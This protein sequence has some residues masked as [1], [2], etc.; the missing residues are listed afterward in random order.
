MTD[1]ETKAVPVSPSALIPVGGS[2]FFNMQNVSDL[3]SLE[4]QAPPFHQA[5][6]RAIIA[7]G[8]AR[9]EDYQ[10]EHVTVRQP[11]AIPTFGVGAQARTREGKRVT[12]IQASAGYT[13][14]TR[15]PVHKVADKR[16]NV[17]LE[18]E[19]NL[20]LML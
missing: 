20:D 13:K 19:S 4:A 11:K 17:W 8:K 15:T 6:N 10:P 9:E 7:S 5:I 14:K 1:K 3:Q 2:N 12:I 18:K 16:G